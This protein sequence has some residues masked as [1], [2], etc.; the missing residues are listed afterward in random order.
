LI[1]TERLL[2]KEGFVRTTTNRIAQLAGTSIGSLYQYFSSK[3]AIVAALVERRI[4]EQM[5]LI[6]AHLEDVQDGP[7]EIAVETFV[8]ELVGLYARGPELDSTLL[9]LIARVDRRAV[10]LSAERSAVALLCDQL[11]RRDPT[12]ARVDLELAA[13]VAVH[14]LQGVIAAVAAHH[15]ER[16][17]TREYRDRLTREMTALTVRYLAPDV[18]R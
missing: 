7:F 9:G 12:S 14:A 17:R 10:M 3:D 2:E 16:L 1:A 4:D 6:R 11:R 15:P 13:F 8:R 5:R 18:S